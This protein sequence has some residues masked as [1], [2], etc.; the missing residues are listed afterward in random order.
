MATGIE[1]SRK[2]AREYINHIKPHHSPSI[3]SISGLEFPEGIALNDLVPVLD[4]QDAALDQQTTL[5]NV[6]ILEDFLSNNKL[7]KHQTTEREAATKLRRSV[8]EAI[9]P[10]SSFAEQSPYAI[11]TKAKL[12]PEVVA[13]YHVLCYRGVLCLS[14]LQTLIPLSKDEDLV[15][16][17][18]C[19]TAFSNPTDQWTCRKVFEETSRLLERLVPL[20]KG[21]ELTD[22]LGQLLRERIKPAFAKSKNPKLTPQ[23]RKAIDPFPSSVATIDDDA[24]SKPW[25]YRN[26]HIPTVFRWILGR[27]EFVEPAFL[28]T[29]WPLLIPPLLTLID[30]SSIQYKAAGCSNLFIFLQSC[31]STIL[32][33]TGLGE[34]FENALMP[35]LLSL[36]TLTD[37][38]DSIL[39]LKQ[40]YPTLVRLTCVRFSEDRQRMQKV[41]A[42]DRIVRYGV[43]RGYA[44]AGEHVKI[45]E[46]L[47]EQISELTEALGVDIVKHMKHILTILSAV[48]ANPFGTAYPP[49]LGASVRSLQK[50]ITTAWPRIG[51][52]R[53]EILK[54]L[55]TCWLKTEVEEHDTTEL[56]EIRCEIERTIQILTASLGD[57]TDVVEEY[58]SL[59][60]G[61]VR[62]KTLLQV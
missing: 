52:H 46:V 51:Y 28:E 61:D 2:A 36:P 54:A 31:P 5:E 30:D 1:A 39:L 35:C 48:L 57:V 26:I 60:E 10:P 53:G 3:S 40:A 13:K 32:E 55:T 6:I 23:G 37:E 29:H 19:L 49:L 43:L 42:L 17:Y 18:T 16:I 15:A 34:I 44:H 4:S 8:A 24:E 58:L 41:K 62:L 33:R 14:H 50:L 59:V 12:T 25:K 11:E 7:D 56:R 22:L 9:L 45:A 27:L 38:A 21:T 20:L 47:V